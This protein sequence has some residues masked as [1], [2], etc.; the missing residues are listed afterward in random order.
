MAKNFQSWFRIK[1]TGLVCLCHVAEKDR[2]GVRFV[3]DSLSC[4][5]EVFVSYVRFFVLYFRVFSCIFEVYSSI[6]EVLSCIFEFVSS[7]FKFL[8][9]I[10]YILYAYITVNICIF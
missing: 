6:F 9:C 2:S 4:I 10:Q 1:I 5:L 7:V 3:F 8:S